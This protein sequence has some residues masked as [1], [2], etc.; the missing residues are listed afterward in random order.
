[1]GGGI[2]P[3][4]RQGSGENQGGG[5]GGNGIGGPRRRKIGRIGS[6]TVGRGSGDKIKMFMPTVYTR[7]FMNFMVEFA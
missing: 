2:P 3:P 4:N 6:P 5:P 1:M 7:I